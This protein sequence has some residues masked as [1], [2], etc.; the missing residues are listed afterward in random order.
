MQYEESMADL[1]CAMR[2]GT[3]TQRVRELVGDMNVLSEQLKNQPGL[4]AHLERGRFGAAARE[5]LRKEYISRY[6]LLR[7]GGPTY[8][9]QGQGEMQMGGDDSALLKGGD[10]GFL[11]S[12]TDSAVRHN[13][14]QKVY[15][16][17]C[18]QLIVTTFIAGATMSLL[19]PSSVLWHICFFGSIA[20]TIAV[21]CCCMC[22]P[23]LMRTYPTNYA[24]MLV[25]TLAESIL[26]GCIGEQY[27]GQSVVIVTFIT[28]FV[29]FGLSV[30]A[31]QTTYDFTGWGPYLFCALLV[32]F[33]FSILVMF[34]GL[35]GLAGSGAFQVVRLV[36]A[37]F[38]AMLFSFY[39]VYDTQLIVGGKHAN[40]FA[41][42][43]YCM[44]ALSLYMDIVQLFLYLLEIFGDR[45]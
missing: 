36:F 11:S 41:V 27:T 23:S 31:C 42:D 30:F 13:F 35:F 38:G 16:I 2:S 17:L 40:M 32:M 33:G 6:V 20:V 12:V 1:E 9:D 25:F 10:D 34:A 24:L 3:S 21:V 29:V 8:P 5:R 43:D 14:V 44:A 39:I 45:K 18:V 7:G 28:A 22:N 37:C 26:V 4:A 15:G 19:E